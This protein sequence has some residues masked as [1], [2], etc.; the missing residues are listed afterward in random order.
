MLEI[1][2]MLG[3]GFMQIVI[4]ALALLIGSVV[5]PWLKEQHAYS[6]IVKFVRA[7]DKLATSGKIA[8]KTKK[9]YVI[10][11]LKAKGI[12]VSPEIEAFIESAVTEL[13]LAIESG[14]LLF[15]DIFTDEEHVLE[16][17]DANEHE[18]EMNVTEAV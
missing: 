10:G 14:V 15:P 17:K 13:D 3:S 9:Q 18:E 6:M 1:Y 8:K 7:A 5:Y 4:G 11:L 12:T 2:E 16:E